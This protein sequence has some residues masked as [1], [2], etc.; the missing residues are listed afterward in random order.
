MVGKF[1]GYLKSKKKDISPS[2]AQLA[3][4]RLSPPQMDAMPKDDS[5]RPVVRTKPHTYQPS[6]AELNK[7]VKI[8]ATQDEL[9][10]AVLRPVKVVEDDDA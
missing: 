10:L 6:K 1:A 3:L 5:E 9:A 4:A 8:G 7:L 2:V